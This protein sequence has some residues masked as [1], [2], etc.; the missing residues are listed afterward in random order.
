MNYAALHNIARRD[1]ETRR[2]IGGVAASDRG[3]ADHAAHELCNLLAT[4]CGS[5][6]LLEGEPLS[7]RARALIGEAIDAVDQCAEL[8]EHARTSRRESETP[9]TADVLVESVTAAGVA[10]R[11]SSNPITVASDGDGDSVRVPLD[12]ESLR[13]AVLS[14]ILE[15]RDAACDDAPIRVFVASQ[16]LSEKEAAVTISVAASAGRSGAPV[17]KSFGEA[18]CPTASRRSRQR[19]DFVSGLARRAG[20]FAETRSGHGLSI[21]FIVLATSPDQ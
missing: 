15:A 1:A 16:R 11:V 18:P 10:R 7:G 21:A 14:L 2:H 20:G 9:R 19:L 8:V 12:P 17:C 6:E 4:I 13:S 5:L 3:A